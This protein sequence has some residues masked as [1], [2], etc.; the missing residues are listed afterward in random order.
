MIPNLLGN[1]PNFKEIYKLAKKYN[2]KVI[3]D[4]A[5][6]IGYSVKGKILVNILMFLPQVSMR[7]I[8]LPGLDLVEWFVSMTKNFMKK[9]N[10]SWMGKIIC[11]F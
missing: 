8:L 4:S 6:T 10:S 2:L 11:G 3:E 5:D 7:L 9:Q 1:I